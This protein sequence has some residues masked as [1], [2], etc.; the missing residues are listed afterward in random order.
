MKKLIFFLLFSIITTSTLSAEEAETLIS[1]KIVNGVFVGPVLK[2]VDIKDKAAFM[3]GGNAGWLINHKLVAGVAG[4]GLMTNINLH[5][6]KPGEALCL[7][8]CYGGALLEFILSSHK[9]LHLSFSTLVGGGS[10]GY[11]GYKSDDEYGKTSA[12]FIT[13][14][15]LNLM[16]NVTK[17][18]RL[19]IGG[20]Y[21]SVSGI[22][23]A[24]INDREL[25]G[26]SASLVFKI[27]YF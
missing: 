10:A 23:L 27:G 22:S 18:F 25:S 24:G 19:G 15:R 16:L 5:S 1:G 7:K 26:L 4:Y 17:H 6:V 9:L 14:P 2:L 21:C 11:K 20:G 3:M 8:L 12:F 13:E